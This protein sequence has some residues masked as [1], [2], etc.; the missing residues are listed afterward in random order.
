MSLAYK[1]LGAFALLLVAFG[2]GFYAGHHV[3]AQ[4]AAAEVSSLKAADAQALAQSQA[5]ARAQEQAADQRQATAKAIYEKDKA[6][7]KA[8]YDS[9]VAALRAGTL[10]LRSEW[11]CTPALAASVQ[12]AAASGSSHDAA[13]DQRDQDAA[14]LVRIAADGDAQIRYLQ[15]VVASDRE[16]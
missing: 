9:D 4:T 15:G 10:K 3:E 11:S 14:T 1:L 13:A 7:A 5:Q 16:Q 6:D 12:S 2:S 8:H